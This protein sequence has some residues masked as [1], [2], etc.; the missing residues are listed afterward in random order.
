MRSSIGCNWPP[1]F[2]DPAL[3]SETKCRHLS[4]KFPR[5]V[6]SWRK[7]TDNLNFIRRLEES[8]HAANDSEFVT[9][10]IDFHHTY[11]SIKT[12][13]LKNLVQSAQFRQGESL[14]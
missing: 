8:I 1:S 9:F 3:G 13:R 10:Y 6:R 7:L 14:R 12:N 11:T 4:N 2:V 5:R